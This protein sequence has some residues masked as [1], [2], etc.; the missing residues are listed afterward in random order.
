MNENRHTIE[1]F[2]YSAE[3]SQIRQGAP[4]TIGMM[5]NHSL[6]SASDPLK[7]DEYIV[8]VTAVRVK[9]AQLNAKR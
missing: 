3:I 7:L 1:L 4:Y 9:L 2:G 6:V 8:F 5:S